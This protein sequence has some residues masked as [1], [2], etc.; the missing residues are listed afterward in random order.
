MNNENLKLILEAFNGILNL[1]QTEDNTSDIKT[2][3][4]KEARKQ[5]KELFDEYQS[6]QPESYEPKKYRGVAHHPHKNKPWQARISFNNKVYNLGCH[7]TPEDAARAYD[8]KAIE[9]LGKKA[10]VNFKEGK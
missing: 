5:A 7:K 10:K 1:I 2:K 3:D 6:N 4:Y 9:L 8:R